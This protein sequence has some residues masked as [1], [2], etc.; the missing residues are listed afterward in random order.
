MPKIFRTLLFLSLILSACL[1]GGFSTA[2][3][4]PTLANDAPTQGS[5]VAPETPASA[6]TTDA[7]D[8]ASPQD[9][10]TVSPSY[11][12]DCGYQWAQK[13][14]PELSDNF[15]QSIQRLQPEAQADAFAFGEDCI[16]A[17]GTATFIPME[18]DFTITLQSSNL[19]DEVVGQW[20]VKIMQ[21]IDTIP[22]D[23][24]VGPRP[25]RVSITLESNGERN[26]VVFYIDQFH[27]LP[28]GLSNT[29]IYQSLKTQQ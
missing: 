18:T 9:T 11:P 20:V 14:L 25:G 15:H 26:G 27:A 6:S 21:V 3:P 12:R 4:L 24:I 23:Q 7:T 10:S 1:P 8:A 5:T 16:Y 28:A 17:D 2:A 19:S 13:A 22:P 29:E